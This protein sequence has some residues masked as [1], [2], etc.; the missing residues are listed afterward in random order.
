MYSLGGREP[1]LSLS[2]GCLNEIGV[3]PCMLESYWKDVAHAITTFRLGGAANCLLKSGSVD[4]PGVRG[5]VS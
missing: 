1:Q 4:V 2:S 3:L 5:M